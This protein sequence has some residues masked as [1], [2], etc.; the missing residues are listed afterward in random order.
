MLQNQSCQAVR[1]NE[2]EIQASVDTVHPA[3]SVRDLGALLDSELTISEHVSKVASICFFQLLRL[4]QIRHLIGRQVTAQLVSA[5]LLSRL[6]YCNS[7]LAGLP[8]STNEPL[9]RVLNAVTRLVVGLK[10]FDSVTPVLKQLH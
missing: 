9:Q 10:T 2:L 8:R 4:R 1:Q 3:T 7:V 5:F 6:D